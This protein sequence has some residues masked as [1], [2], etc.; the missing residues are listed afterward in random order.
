M[1]CPE[2]GKKLKHIENATNENYICK[3]CKSMW[4]IVYVGELE[5]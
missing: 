5:E 2:C 4:I 3:S 1:N